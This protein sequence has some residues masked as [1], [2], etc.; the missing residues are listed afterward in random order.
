MASPEISY[1][2][3]YEHDYYAWIREQVRALREHRVEE[4]DW[5]NVAE[6]IEDLGK[7]ERRSVESHLE[8]LLLHALKLSYARGLSRDRNARLWEN[9]IELA[10]SEVRRLLDE[11]PSLRPM[12]EELIN[13]AY[14]DAR[15]S[16]RRAL[17]FPKEPLPETSP[18]TL[19][20]VLDDNF[21]PKPVSMAG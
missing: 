18:W 21:V 17:G 2:E 19:E 4:V 16:A 9:T 10:R 15:I 3:L 20:Q 12:L 7:S 6:E 14:K 1:P 5:E 11:S 8:T 13:N